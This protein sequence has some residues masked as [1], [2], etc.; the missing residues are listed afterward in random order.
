MPAIYHAAIAYLMLSLYEGFSTTIVEAITV[1]VPVVAAK[2]SSLEEV[3]GPGSIYVAPHDRTALVEAVDRLL[4]SEE[5]RQRM[6]AEGREYATRFRPEVIAYNIL[7]CYRRIGI[8]I[9]M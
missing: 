8:D 9:P 3:G 1:G 5:L 7:N 6:I 2:G 4:L